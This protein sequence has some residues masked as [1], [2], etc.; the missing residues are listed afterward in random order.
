[1]ARVWERIDSEHKQYSILSE[2]SFQQKIRSYCD[3]YFE[4][5]TQIDPFTRSAMKSHT[6]LIDDDFL[7]VN[8]A[9]REGYM[10]YK[11]PIT[12]LEFSDWET[13]VKSIDNESA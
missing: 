2:M 8:L 10:A 6:L 12:G 5:L 1:M 3:D 9:K 4:S 7:N 13:I 11:V